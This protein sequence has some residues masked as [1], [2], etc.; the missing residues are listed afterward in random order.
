MREFYI[1]LDAES[2][3]GALVEGIESN[4][5][6]SLPPFIRE[7]DLDARF[8]FFRRNAEGSERPFRYVDP[9]GWDLTVGVGQRNAKPTGGEFV[10]TEQIVPD[11]TGYLP[12]NGTTTITAAAF[13]T[14]IRTLTSYPNATVTGEI[15]GPFVLDRVTDG[16]IDPPIIGSELL[17]PSGSVGIVTPIQDGAVNR[18]AIVFIEFARGT[19]IGRSSGWSAFSA[20]AV[21][22]SVHQTGSGTANKVFKLA[23]NPDAYAGDTTLAFTGDTTTANVGPIPYNATPEQIVAFFEAHVDVE[24]G[25][26]AVVQACPGEYYITCLG[27]GILLSNT[28][29]LAERANTLKVPVGLHGKL[30]ANTQGISVLLDGE[31]EA[32]ATFEVRIDSGDGPETAVL[33]TGARVLASLLRSVVG[34]SEPLDPTATASQVI[35]FFSAIVGKTGGGSTKLDGL[36]TINRTVG[37]QVAFYDATDGLMFYRLVSG[38]DAESSPA[39]IRPDD[40]A[41]TTNEKVWKLDAIKATNL[42]TLTGAETL[43]NK[44]ATKPVITSFTVATVST[45]TTGALAY[46]TDEA[47]GAVLAVA[48][49]ANWRRTTDRAIIS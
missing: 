15:G 29:A 32:E 20:A 23:W 47:G 2:A 33:D 24:G 42:V 27:V 22:C 26:V 14:A 48:D 30:N 43:T 37:S 7:S 3:E 10:L 6:A 9:A 44:T 13:Q 45:P 18:N 5:P 17:Q 8:H 49:G 1:N 34:V 16:V 46:I 41:G 12:Y 25:G 40:Y 31:D 19:P 39:V 38:T 35:R 4:V 28:P 36:L 11:D 21:T